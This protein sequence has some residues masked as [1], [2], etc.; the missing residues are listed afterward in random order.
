MQ[1]SENN[2]NDCSTVRTNT[3]HENTGYVDAV[4]PTTTGASDHATNVG[5]DSLY[6]LTAVVPCPA[7]TADQYNA[8][9]DTSH[10]VTIISAC[11]CSNEVYPHTT[12]VGEQRSAPVI[13]SNLTFHTHEL[14]P[15]PIP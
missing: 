9:F 5:K 1:N 11:T 14:I 13:V 12:A 3:P 2:P 7:V 6:I 15:T 8:T 10:N 4:K